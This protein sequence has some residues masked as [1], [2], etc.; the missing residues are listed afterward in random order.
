MSGTR[1]TLFEQGDIL[2][3]EPRA[4]TIHAATLDQLDELGVYS[5]IEP[6]GIIC[7][8]MRYWDRATGE[9]IAEF[10]H[11]VL[12]AETSHPWV[13]QCEQNKLS[14][15]LF[16]MTAAF[17][18]IEVHNGAKVVA[19]TQTADRVDVRARL[20]NG[21]EQ[22]YS[23]EYLVGADGARS[24]VRE[25]FGIPF[26]G[27]TYPERFL[28][29][30]TPFDFKAQ[31]GYD[32]RNYLFDPEEW[33]TLFKIAWD[34]PPGVWRLVTPARP[35]ETPET[36]GDLKTAQARLQRFL[37]RS[38]AYEIPFYNWYTVDQRVA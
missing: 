21:T 13:L 37:P 29:I 26:E 34:G 6:L 33:A 1:A 28:I 3:Q 2:H 23:A 32:Y 4:T 14:R 30:S 19:C 17:P 20:S 36:L 18:S 31:Q 25:Q 22:A 38:E 24:T 9:L 10:D 16:E 7:P 27:F 11:A 8:T 12:A 5:R 15:V 35:D